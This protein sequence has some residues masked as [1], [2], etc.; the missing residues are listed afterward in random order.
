MGV[1]GAFSAYGLIHFLRK[2]RVPVFA[3]ALAAGIISDWATY[4]TTSL[5]LSS[6]LH[7]N[8]SFWRMFA[9][10]MAAFVPTQLPLG[11]AEGVVTAL[12]Y[13]FVLARRPDLLE[14]RPASRD[15][16]PHIAGDNDFRPDVLV[17]P[18]RSR[19]VT[20]ADA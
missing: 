11:I 19:Q 20:G 7:G 13:R 8:G 14:A 10:I 4:A 16:D 2:M 5:E 15:L 6:A 3:A 17:V 18:A 12:A 1:V 9:F